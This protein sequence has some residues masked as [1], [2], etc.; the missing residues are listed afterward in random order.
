MFKLAVQGCSVLS[1]LAGC[2]QKQQDSM[3]VT[4]EGCTVGF[5]GAT[6]FGGVI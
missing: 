6:A 1:T 3:C 5:W 4:T 2:G